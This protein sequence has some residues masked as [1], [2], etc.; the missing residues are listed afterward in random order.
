MVSVCLPRRALLLELDERP[1]DVRLASGRRAGASRSASCGSAPGE[2]RVP[3][4]KRATKSW[5]WAIFFCFSAFSDS[6]RDAHL[7][8]GHH[9][10]VV[11]ARVG[12]DGLVVDVGDVGADRVQEVAV[13]ARWRPARPRS[14]RGTSRASGSSR[15]R[16]CWWARRA[17]APRACRTAP[18]RAA[19]AAC[20]RRRSRCIGRSWS[21]SG[22]P[23]AGEQLAGV[24]LGGVAVL[25]G[26]DALELAEA[27]PVVVGEVGL[28]RAAP[29]SRASP[30]R[31]PCCPAAPRRGR[32]RPRRRTGPACSTEVFFGPARPCRCRARARRRGSS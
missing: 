27:V 9:H 32:A 6:I 19:R 24:G 8:L 25:L 30:P 12:D 17:A 31:A 1:L 7:A 4:E 16:G 14:S 13:V 15:G 2:A 21:S 29:P 28:A 26:D 11:A 5:S 20:S 3:A 23:E 10:V 18:G 22:M